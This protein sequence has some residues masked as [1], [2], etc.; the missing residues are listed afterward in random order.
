MNHV[1]VAADAIGLDCFL[2][3]LFDLD[4]LRFHPKRENR[5]MSETILRLEKVS[6]D[7][8]VVGNMAVIAGAETSVAAALP[9]CILRIHYMAI[10]AGKRTVREVGNGLGDIKNV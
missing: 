7:P 2:P 3:R 9:S 10:H 6:L 4:Y 8:V 5:G 1:R